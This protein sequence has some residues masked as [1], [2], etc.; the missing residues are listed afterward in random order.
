MAKKVKVDKWKNSYLHSLAR[1][2]LEME[3][4]PADLNNYLGLICHNHEK[5]CHRQNGI[6]S[7][8][9]AALAVA[10]WQKFTPGLNVDYGV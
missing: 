8:Q 5:L 1:E 7:T 10:T 9:I 3:E 2:I 4:L 6:K